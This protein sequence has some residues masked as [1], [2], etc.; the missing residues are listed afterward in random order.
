MFKYETDDFS[1]FKVLELLE[2]KILN[3]LKTDQQYFISFNL[4]NAIIE[5]LS[6]NDNDFFEENHTWNNMEKGE[7][8]TFCTIL[9]NRVAVF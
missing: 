5:L 7:G 9:K 3:Y 8:M 2:A 4:F 6:S 1:D